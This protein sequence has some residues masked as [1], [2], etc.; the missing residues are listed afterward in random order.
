M[1]LSKLSLDLGRRIV[2]VLRQSLEDEAKVAHLDVVLDAPLSCDGVEL[3]TAECVTGLC[4]A[5]PSSPWQH[6]LQVA[7]LLQGSH[8]PGTAVLSVGADVKVGELAELVHSA[9][10]KNTWTCLQFQRLR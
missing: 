9:W 10:K 4:C 8:R 1:A 5:A 3:G 2:E 6:Q 7:A